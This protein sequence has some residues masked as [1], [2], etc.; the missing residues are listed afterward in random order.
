MIKLK[1]KSQIVSPTTC[2]VFWANLFALSGELELSG[3]SS[4][5]SSSFLMGFSREKL[6]ERRPLAFLVDFVLLPVM[7][8]CVDTLGVLTT[9]DERDL[10]FLLAGN[11]TEGATSGAFTFLPFKGKILALTSCKLWSG[12]VIR[13]QGMQLSM[14]HFKR[15][16]EYHQLCFFF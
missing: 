3:W 13:K 1:E 15:E 10:S 5:N 9:K 6:D 8:A 14:Q 11:G 16:C 4:S 7:V 2:P 12:L